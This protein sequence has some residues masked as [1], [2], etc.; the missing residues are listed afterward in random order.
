MHSLRRKNSKRSP[1]SK[2]LTQ[3]VM[4][5]LVDQ[6]SSRRLRPGDKLPSERE[7]IAQFGVSRTVVRDA[8]ARLREQ[9]LV[10]SRQ[11]AGVFIRA[12]MLPPSSNA[13]IATLSAIV[14]TIEV[15]A[16]IEIEA[17]RLAAMRGSPAQM[18]EIGQKWDALLHAKTAADA[19]AADLA[20]HLSIARATNNSRFVEFFDFLGSRTIPRAQLRNPRQRTKFPSSYNEQLLEEHRRIC[21]AILKRDSNAAGEAMRVHLKTSQERYIALMRTGSIDA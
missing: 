16:A 5:A 19:E 21:E 9:G 7:M 13:S 1:A 12:G 17:A 11:G 4:E 14:E 8:I 18:A 20:F 3:H 15:R 10:E 6:I 2:S